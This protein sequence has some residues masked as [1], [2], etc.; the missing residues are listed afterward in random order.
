MSKSLLEKTVYQHRLLVG[1]CHQ[2]CTKEEENAYTKA[3][4]MEAETAQC[5]TFARV[6]AESKNE[7]F[8]T[9]NVDT[10]WNAMKEV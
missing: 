4:S 7:V 10:K 5:K 2:W 8:E 1:V 6:V 3:E 9:D